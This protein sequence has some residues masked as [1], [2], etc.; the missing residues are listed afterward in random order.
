MPPAIIKNRAGSVLVIG[1]GVSGLTTALSLAR[2]GLEVKVVAEKPASQCVSAVAGALW[3]WPPAVC[4][5]HH[6]QISLARSKEWC[7]QA[8]EIFGGLAADPTT[9]VYMRMSNFYFTHKIEESPHDLS[10]M[11]ELAP[12]V[13]GFVRDPGLA[14]A[15]GV[16]PGYGI[17][18]AYAHIAPM[19]DTN[20]YTDWLL[21]QVENEGIPVTWARVNGRLADQEKSLRDAYGVDAIVNCTGLG[22]A[23]LHDKP[24]YPLRG[25]LVRVINDGSRMPKIDQA[26]CVSHDERHG[27]EQDIVFIVPRGEGLVVLGGLAERDEW[28]TNISLENH[29]PVR[30]MYDRCIRFMPDIEKAQIDPAEPV[31]AGLR[32]FRG[33]NVCLET[34][35]GTN[36]VHNYAHGGAGFSFSWG[37]AREAVAMTKQLTSR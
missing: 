24:M 22:A 9:G 12:R 31:R 21:K 28:D 37:C 34:E 2:D 3:E 23:E 25:A 29:Q 36:I 35:P 17:Q 8:Y 19:I 27:D 7:M 18:D 4:G 13:T 26:H 6:D 20:V 11:N 14:E 1:A 5:Y 10:K 16:S 15:N 30:D 33:Q 32:P